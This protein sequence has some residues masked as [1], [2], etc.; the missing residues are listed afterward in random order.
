LNQPV[1]KSGEKET[2]VAIAA[3]ANA[4]PGEATISVTG[5]PMSG[6]DSTVDLTLK[7]AAK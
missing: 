7:V 2:T 5:H 3:A 4:K 1:I 6:E